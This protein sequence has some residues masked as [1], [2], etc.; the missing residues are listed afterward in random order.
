[1]SN[2]PKLKESCFEQFAVGLYWSYA[3]LRN[4]KILYSAKLPPSPSMWVKV[5]PNPKLRY[6]FAI[7]TA[8]LSTKAALLSGLF[9]KTVC[10][11]SRFEMLTQMCHCSWQISPSSFPTRESPLLEQS[12]TEQVTHSFLVAVPL[13][14]IFAPQSTEVLDVVKHFC[15]MRRS[16]ACPIIRACVKLTYARMPGHAP[17]PILWHSVKICGNEGWKLRFVSCSATLSAIRISEVSKMDSAYHFNPAVSG[18]SG[19]E[20][21]RLRAVFR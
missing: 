8:L 7:S 9:G 16:E 10:V 5:L 1:M 11:C 21:L 20:E 15:A 6:S 4:E 14:I 2:A 12:R 19:W 13:F 3:L 17:P 18:L